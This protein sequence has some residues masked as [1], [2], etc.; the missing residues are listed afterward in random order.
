MELARLFHDRKPG[1][2]VVV[3]FVDGEDFG[4]AP[5][6]MFLGSKAFAENWRSVMKPA[7]GFREFDYG[8]LLDMVGDKDLQIRK[9]GF[10]AQVAPDL[11]AKVWA[12][13]GELGYVNYFKPDKPD[14]RHTIQDDHLPLLAAGI[15]CIDII[16]FDYAYWHTLDDTADKCS[17]ESLKVV[18]DVVAR[19]VYSESETPEP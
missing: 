19:V 13:A 6:E 12:A 1:V 15:K 9:E 4:A 14:H 7:K 18:G 5:D 3:L 16:D 8:L 17:A 2:G 10:S 11:V